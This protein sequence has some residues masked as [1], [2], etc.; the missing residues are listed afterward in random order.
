MSCRFL[1]LVGQLHT[2]GLERQL[3]YLLQAMDRERYSPAVAVWKYQDKD[4]HVPLIRALGV[5]L[6]SFTPG[7]SRTARLA[8]F[9]SLVKHL[10]PEVV[11]SYSFYTNFAAYYGARGTDAVAVGS[12]R[13]DFILDKKWT[14]LLL[15][16]LSARW[17]AQQICNSSRA[18]EN[19]R[20]SGG[21][22]VPGRPFV[23]RNGLDLKRFQSSPVM[24]YKTTRILA[25]FYLLSA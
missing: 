25:W 5:P 4:I 9:R 13:N 1:Y 22:F 3:Y 21:F 2:G 12:I 18:A 10:E 6:H 15:G 24:T 7:F 14:G 16:R 23:V 11:H 8:A 20:Q 17:P 19:A